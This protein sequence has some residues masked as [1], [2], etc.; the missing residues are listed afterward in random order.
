MYYFRLLALMICLNATH[1]V[2]DTGIY[3]DTK[4]IDS[5][6]HIADLL[7]ENASPTDADWSALFHSAGYSSLIANEIPQEKL[8]DLI[9]K[10]FSNKSATDRQDSTT[11]LVKLIEHFRH[12]DQNRVK[13]AATLKEFAAEVANDYPMWMAMTSGYLPPAAN[14]INKPNKIAVAV[15][16]LDARGYE[17]GI[18]IDPL[19]IERYK[20]SIGYFIAHEFHHFYAN[21][22]RK[23]PISSTSTED[24][25]LQWVIWQLHSEGMADMID[26]PTI[27]FAKG[28]M[29]DTPYAAFFRKSYTQSAEIIQQLDAYLSQYNAISDKA[30][31]VAEIKNSIPMSGHPTGYFIAK[32]IEQELG[33]EALV[34]TLGFPNE[35]FNR[36]N[37]AAAKNGNL[38]L[39]SSE[40]LAVINNLVITQPQ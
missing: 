10:T 11:P 5:L 16:S 7:K 30:N 20:S 29:A 13:I 9:I 40:A 3:V 33:R 6:W 32:T 14:T 12:A 34:Q 39:F 24:L 35:F 26:K 27:Y 38:P 37:E 2:A 17:E 15:F 22:L 31:L 28:Y 23:P 25:N 18:V 19:F 8:K 36:Y 1:V 4:S 21:S